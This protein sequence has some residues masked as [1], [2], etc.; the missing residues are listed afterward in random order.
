[1][2]QYLT[3]EE[4]AS[5]GVVSL[6]GW[7]D[8]EHFSAVGL[9][10]RD[11]AI[12]RLLERAEHFERQATMNEQ[13]AAGRQGRARGQAIGDRKKAEGARKAAAKCR[14]QIEQLQAAAA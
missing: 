3:D 12:A 6:I 7:K 5:F 2:N 10:R 13:I 14:A 9:I 1:M 8:H 4:I 11:F